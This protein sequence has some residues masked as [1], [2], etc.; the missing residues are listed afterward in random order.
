MKKLLGLL[1]YLIQCPLCHEWYDDETHE[2][3]CPHEEL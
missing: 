3:E 2:G 1:R